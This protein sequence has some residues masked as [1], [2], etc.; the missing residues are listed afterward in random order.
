[1]NTLSNTLLEWFSS[2][3]ALTMGILYIIKY[4]VSNKEILKMS[5]SKSEDHK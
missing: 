4:N 2:D 3:G 1:M 5:K